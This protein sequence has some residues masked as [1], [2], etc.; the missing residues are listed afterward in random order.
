MKREMITGGIPCPMDSKEEWSKD[1]RD[2]VL[3]VLLPMVR[4]RARVSKVITWAYE[5]GFE[6]KSDGSSVVPDVGY[7][8]GN[9]KDPMGVAHDYLFWLHDNGM[10]DPEGH[11]WGLT[12]CNVWY[13]QAWRDFKHP[14]IGAVW[15]TGLFIGS[16]YRWYFGAPKKLP[17]VKNPMGE[18]GPDGGGHT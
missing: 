1:H 16:W 17:K 4:P 3:N 13:F 2:F 7:D 5:A 15:F 10:A 9:I 6:A 14:I 12:E 8:Y 18:K 11:K